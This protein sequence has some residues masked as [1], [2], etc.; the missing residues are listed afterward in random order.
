MPRSRSL[1]PIAA[2]A[3]ASTALLA[4]CAGVAGGG[5]AEINGSSGGSSGGDCAGVEVVV[6][7]DVLDGT[8][9][10][11]C[12]NT[13]SAISASDALT[14]AGVTTEGTKQYGDAVVCRVNGLPSAT[15]P[16]DV[17]GQAVT[18]SCDAM[19]SANAY[20]S[21]WQKT[22]SADWGYATTGV[23]DITLNPGDALG[24]VFTVN[25]STA[26]PVAK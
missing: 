10:A 19:P 24:L 6:N 22:G 2:L 3:L 20:W 4:G 12:L 15:E 8:D 18:E 1:F 14:Q 7:F 23:A 5:S 11:T 16:F 26:S 9:I 25:N 21:L 13:S 17:A